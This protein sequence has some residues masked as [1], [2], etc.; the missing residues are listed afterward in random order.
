MAY[1]N[2]TPCRRPPKGTSKEELRALHKQKMQGKFFRNL[3]PGYANG[4]IVPYRSKPDPRL[5]ITR[6]SG[7]Y[8]PIRHP[9][10]GV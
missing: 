2:R 7:A 9:H 3:E 5:Q 10:Y 8:R 6:Q 1:I 4:A